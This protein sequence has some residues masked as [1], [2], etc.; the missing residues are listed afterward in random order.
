MK[1][2]IER[3]D[4][5][6][7]HMQIIAVIPYNKAI[8]EARQFVVARTRRWRGTERTPVVLEELDDAV[9]VGRQLRAELVSGAR[10]RGNRKRSHAYRRIP[11]GFHRL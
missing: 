6:S 1:R 9:E 5:N 8:N 11:T 3:Y 7:S 10:R 4:H 2:I